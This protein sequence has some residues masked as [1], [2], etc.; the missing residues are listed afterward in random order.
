MP[1]DPQRIQKLFLE[2]VELPPAERLAALERESDGDAELHSRVA[3]LLRA[4]DAPGR[5]FD[6]LDSSLEVTFLTGPS[7]SPRASRDAVETD[8]LVPPLAD[9]PETAAPP[10]EGHSGVEIAGRYRLQEKIGEGGMGEVWVARQTEPV[11]RHV[12]L[13]LIKA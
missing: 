12:A 9:F 4:H 7:G 10:P 8:P 1:V 2:L 5:S 11:K 13:K 3:A 6:P